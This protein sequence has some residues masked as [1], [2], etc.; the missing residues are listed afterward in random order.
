MLYK[1]K[2]KNGLGY[3]GEVCFLCESFKDFN[4]ALTSDPDV[5]LVD[6]QEISMAE[7]LSEGHPIVFANDYYQKCKNK[8]HIP[9][10]L[11]EN[12]LIEQ[13]SY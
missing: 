7:V 9:L 2:I 4:F 10:P 1:A 11:S 5:V 12:C 3:T 8:D 6:L 13:Q